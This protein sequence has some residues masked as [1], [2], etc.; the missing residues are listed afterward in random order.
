MEVIWRKKIDK[1]YLFVDKKNKEICIKG[2]LG[3]CKQVFKGEEILFKDG[4]V[5]VKSKNSF[6]Y[7]SSR[8]KSLL[9]GVSSGYFIE[10]S[11]VGRGYRFIDLVDKLLVKLGYTHYLEY[12]PSKGIKFIG[13]RNNLLI[14]GLDL[15]EVNRVGAL[16]RGFM[17]PEVYKGKGIR[18]VGEEIMLK[19]GKK[20]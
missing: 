16:I 8:I 3:E 9:E 6:G 20:N 12:K 18:Y 11:I 14:F 15:E 2:K 17:K 5:L 19:V 13:S 4:A 10:L 7:L 1:T